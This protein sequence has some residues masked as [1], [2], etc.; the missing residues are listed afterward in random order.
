MDECKDK[1]LHNTSTR[2]L[3]QGPP[4]LN[5][6][7][8]PLSHC[9]PYFVYLMRCLKYR[10]GMAN[11]FDQD[12]TSPLQCLTTSICISIRVDMAT[13]FPQNSIK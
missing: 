10:V 12:Q 13:G 5:L 6:I 3:N 11:S 4:D 9:A 2:G 1:V 8:Q 7:T